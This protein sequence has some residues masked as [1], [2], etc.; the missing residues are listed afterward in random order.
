MSNSDVKCTESQV[1][2]IRNLV[3]NY[4]KMGDQIKEVLKTFELTETINIKAKG[5]GSSKPINAKVLTMKPDIVDFYKLD[6]AEYPASGIGSIIW[7]KM[8]ERA[9]KQK[10]EKSGTKTIRFP[11]D[12]E[13]EIATGKFLIVNK[14]EKIYEY[15]DSENTFIES[16]KK[17]LKDDFGISI[18]KGEIVIGPLNF[19]CFKNDLVLDEEAPSTSKPEKKDKGDKKEKK[20]SDKKKSGDKPDK[21]EKKDKKKGKKEKVII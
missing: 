4:N 11:E 20:S 12:S 6:D 2:I 17:I 1:D 13:G 19:T 15:I 5:R 9:A 8:K 7:K 21:K 3:V 16:N 14:N 10:K 18:V